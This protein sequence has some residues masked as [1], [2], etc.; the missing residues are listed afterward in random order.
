MFLTLVILFFCQSGKCTA[1]DW[2][3][4]Q[5]KTGWHLEKKSN[6]CHQKCNEKLR[7]EKNTSVATGET[8][9]LTRWCLMLFLFLFL[10][11]QIGGS[12]YTVLQ[13]IILTDLECL[14]LPAKLCLR[15]RLTGPSKTKDTPGEAWFSGNKKRAR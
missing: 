2:C 7:Q 14:C 8:K 9:K 3:T 5:S 12:H 1:D 11:F 6:S 13:N 10:F 15:A 4:K